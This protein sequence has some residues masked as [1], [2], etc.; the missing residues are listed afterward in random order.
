ME[1]YLQQNLLLFSRRV[2]ENELYHSGHDLREFDV[3]EFEEKRG[4]FVTLHK[5]GKLR[6][7]IGRLEAKSSIYDNVIDLSKAAAFEDH[8]FSNLTS[9]E[10][11]T[12]K[13]EIS[14]LTV[15][16]ELEG[17]STF[18]KMLQIKPKKDGV[19]LST[20][21]RNA[22]FLPQV[23]E[24]VPIREDFISELCRKAGLPKDYWENNNL[25]ISVY[26]VEYFEES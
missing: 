4:M 10:L 1:A 22:T 17:T 7:C 2:L 19:I 18:E 23:W 21:A 6:G 26:R 25:D 13:I 8:R 9:K 24:S 12:V 16:E 14:L 11:K 20:G 5:K 15:P 3:P